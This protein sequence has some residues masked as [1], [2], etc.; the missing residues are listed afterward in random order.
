LA[1]GQRPEATADL[2]M[3]RCRYVLQVIDVAK[4]LSLGPVSC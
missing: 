1:R 2:L 3:R 4:G